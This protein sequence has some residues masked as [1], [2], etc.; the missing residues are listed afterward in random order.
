MATAAGGTHPTGM[1]SCST[2]V[3]KVYKFNTPLCLLFEFS[4]ASDLTIS[5]DR[6][7]SNRCDIHTSYCKSILE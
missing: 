7:S 5:T 3:Q 4:H 6:S 2:Y 1:N